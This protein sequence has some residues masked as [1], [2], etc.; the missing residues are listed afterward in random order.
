MG[1]PMTLLKIIQELETFDNE[2]TIYAS[3]P[4]TENSE[5]LVLREPGEKI[6]LEGEKLGLIYFLEVSIAQDFLED[7]AASLDTPP[8][9]QQKCKR[10]IQYATNDA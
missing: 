9:L 1:T 3:R 7:W 10:L 2:S 4:W 8:M 5:A 6:P